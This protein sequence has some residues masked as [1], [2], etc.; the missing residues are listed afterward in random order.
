VS[1]E[2][3]F[4]LTHSDVQ[5]TVKQANAVSNEKNRELFVL[6][7]GNGAWKITRY[8]FNKLPA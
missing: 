1:G 4:A 5:I 2:Y 7:N 8:M 3:A 6:K